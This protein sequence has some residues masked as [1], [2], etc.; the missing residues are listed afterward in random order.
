MKAKI[1][2]I[3]VNYEI[4]GKEGAPWLTFSHS[5]ACSLRMDP[6]LAA[7]KD[8]F[9]ILLD[10]RGHGGEAPTLPLDMLA[11]RG[12]A[13]A[14]RRAQDPAHALL[15]TVDGRHDRPGRRP[16]RPGVFD[17]VVL[18]DAGHAQTPKPASSGKSASDRGDPRHAAA[19]EPDDR[20][21]VHQGFQDKPVVDTIRKLIASTP[22]PGY[23]GCCHAISNLNT[24]RLKEIATRCSRS[25]A[26]RTRRRRE[27]ATSARTC[28]GRSWW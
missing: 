27:R 3:E 10:T 20:A 15:R 16:H 11:E 26:S 14:A 22:V 25:P 24:A 21:L 6:Q 5:L 18:A 7:F 23:V 8:R 28:R 9:S 2:G 4:H 12:S 1:N 13:P 19:A 17:R